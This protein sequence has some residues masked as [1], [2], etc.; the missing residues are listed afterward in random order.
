[1][2]SGRSLAGKSDV[3][4]KW[5]MVCL[6]LCIMVL[7]LDA[8]AI[9]ITAGKSL[10][11]RGEVLTA[12]GA[13]S[14]SLPTSVQVFAPEILLLESF[15][16]CSETGTF[17]FSYNTTFL[18]P[19][20]KWTLVVS[21]GSETSKTELLV[22]DAREA[23]FFFLRFLSPTP[24]KYVRTE[25]ISLSIEVTDSGEKVNDANLAFFGFD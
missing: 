18:D 3:M 8:G 25:T 15:V 17:D 24:G 10:I 9:S 12:N 6:V 23:G 13:C 19:T 14:P 2:I 16:S 1:M 11:T 20:G 21:D 5:A 7:A 22:D 4:G